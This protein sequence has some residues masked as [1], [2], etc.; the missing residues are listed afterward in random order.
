M[1]DSSWTERHKSVYSCQCCSSWPHDWCQQGL[2]S[3]KGR[4]IILALSFRGLVHQG[5][6]G[7]KSEEVWEGREGKVQLGSSHP[8]RSQE[9][10]ANRGTWLTFIC[11]SVQTNGIV[12]CT[13]SVDIPSAGNPPRKL[14]HSTH[15]QVHLTKLWVF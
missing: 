12:L 10:E 1:L 7:K 6:K 2:V 4:K 11:A 5:K 8:P 9:A 13:P 14:H 3:S 15:S